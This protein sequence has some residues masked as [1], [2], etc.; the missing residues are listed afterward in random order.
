M[1]EKWRSRSLFLTFWPQE[2]TTKNSKTRKPKILINKCNLLPAT[3]HNYWTSLHSRLPRVQNQRLDLGILASRVSASTIRL[4]AV[5]Y[6]LHYPG[7]EERNVAYKTAMTNKFWQKSFA[8]LEYFCLRWCLFLSIWYWHLVGMGM[9]WRTC[10]GLDCSCLNV[11][12]DKSTP[13]N[14][15]KLHEQ[16][17][18]IIYNYTSF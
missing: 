17:V 10:E 16:K 15:N 6:R 13:W 12:A 2:C 7:P 18:K 3:C 1:L 11:M 5:P 4:K 8:E 9:N 14:V